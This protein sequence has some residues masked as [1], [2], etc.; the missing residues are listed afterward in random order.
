MHLTANSQQAGLQELIREALRS[1]R[2]PK[3]LA[4]PAMGVRHCSVRCSEG[5]P[6]RPEGSSKNRARLE[7]HVAG[8]L[9]PAL[10]GTGLTLICPVFGFDHFA[11]RC[12]DGG[13]GSIDAALGLSA[14]DLQGFRGGCPDGSCLGPQR[15]PRLVRGR[16]GSGGR[17]PNLQAA[18]VTQR[19]QFPR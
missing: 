3:L 12:P 17:Q 11:D 5:C 16:A 14:L 18:A 15:Q 1:H 19:L 10:R 4:P 9:R 8:P 7:F 13:F 2:P 6:T